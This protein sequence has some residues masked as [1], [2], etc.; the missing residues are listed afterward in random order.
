MFGIW[1]ARVKI[2]GRN[3]RIAGFKTEREAAIKVDMMLLENN[4]EPVN[5]LKRK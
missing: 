1:E 3:Q 2:G 4:K 5:I